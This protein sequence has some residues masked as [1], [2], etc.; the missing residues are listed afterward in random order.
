MPFHSYLFFDTEP[1]MNGL[2]AAELEKEKKAFVACAEVAPGVRMHAYATLALKAGS[3]F[4]LH[5]NAENSEA[6]QAA[7]R[8]L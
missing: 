4:M 5:V 3:R 1:S 7:A 2:S 6:I 8:D